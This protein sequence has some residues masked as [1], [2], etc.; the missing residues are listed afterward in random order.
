MLGWLRPCT[1]KTEEGLMVLFFGL[2]FFSLPPLRLPPWKISA[3]ALGH[4]IIQN[5]F[6][7]KPSQQIPD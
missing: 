4:A 2:V 3:D 5:Y 1:D 7:F 6:V